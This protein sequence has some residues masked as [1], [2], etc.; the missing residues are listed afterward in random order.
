M[1]EVDPFTCS[2]YFILN[3]NSFCFGAMS[4]LPERVCVCVCVCVNLLF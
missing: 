4:K 1:I 3:L 2:V